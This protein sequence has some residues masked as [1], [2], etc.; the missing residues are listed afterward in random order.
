[1]GGGA[2]EVGKVWGGGPSEGRPPWWGAMW[3]HRR[4]A[5]VSRRGETRF[6]WESPIS[7]PTRGGRGKNPL[8]QGG[9]RGGGAAFWIAFEKDKVVR[10]GPSKFSWGVSIFAAPVCG[11]GGGADERLGPGGR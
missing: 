11:S 4:G 5:T 9:A 8:G 3:V 10:G 2:Q 1:L 6:R 7:R